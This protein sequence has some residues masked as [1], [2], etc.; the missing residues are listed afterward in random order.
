MSKTNR[1][2]FSKKVIISLAGRVA[3]LCSNP[4][5]R[6]GTIGPNTVRDRTTLI[7][8]AAHITAAAP[9]G[10]RY[11]STLTDV[12]RKDI[13]NGIW[14]CSN[15]SIL[16]DRDE[17]AFPIATLKKWRTEAEEYATKQLGNTSSVL[18]SAR[19]KIEAILLWQR[20]MSSNEGLVDRPRPDDIIHIEDARFLFKNARFYKL[21]LINNSSVTAV[22]M[23]IEQIGG[24]TLTIHDDILPVNN[25][26]S[27]EEKS[28]NCELVTSYI[29]TGEERA[30][31]EATERGYP[32]ELSQIQ[33]CISY[34]DEHGQEF[35]TLTS[36]SGKQPNNILK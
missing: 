2:N 5:C 28:I 1:D 8:I 30:A 36:F 20:G 26:K 29:M 12:Q 11:V 24:V 10:P 21:Q 4:F 16:I 35:Q 17:K 31:I 32:T 3:Y 27:F 25:L 18:Y 33:L 15:C 22:N 6:R 19:P 13:D 14:L 7:G 34:K 23:K 9:G